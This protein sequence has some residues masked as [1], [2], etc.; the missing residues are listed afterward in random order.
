MMLGIA[1]KRQRVVA[2]GVRLLSVLRLRLHKQ[3][4]A[5][6]TMP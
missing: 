4:D 5:T 1:A 2:A 6:R 3:V